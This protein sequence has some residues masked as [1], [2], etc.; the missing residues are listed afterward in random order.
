MLNGGKKEPYR[1]SR[2]CAKEF[3]AQ[4]ST[5]FRPFL[6]ILPSQRLIR[7]CKSI[8][9]QA[10]NNQ[11]AR[12]SEEVEMGRLKEGMLLE[13]WIDTHFF[14]THLQWFAEWLDHI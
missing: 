5:D 8:V 2:S 13:R 14:S 3:H 6:G 12:L 11:T 9:S 4:M 1:R 10:R 7:E